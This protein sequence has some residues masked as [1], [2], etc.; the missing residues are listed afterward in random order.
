MKKT[1]VLIFL[2]A[3][4]LNC[5]A[6]TKKYHIIN[7][8]HIASAGKW[9]YIAINPVNHDIYVSHGTQVNILSKQGDSVGVILN[10]TGV[11]GI[12]FVPEFNKGFISNGKLNTVTVFDLANKQVIAQV[13][14]G[15]NPDAIMFDTFSKMVFVCNGHSN[16]LTII[17]PADNKVVNTIALGGKPETAVSDGAGNIYI[18]IEDK[19]EI[20]QL[21]AK[22]YLVQARWPLGKGEEPSGLAIDNKTHRLFSG[23]GNKLLAVV[24]AE[25][26]KIVENIPIGDE[27]DGVVFD[28]SLKQVFVS[29]GEGLLTVIKEESPDKYNV[30]DNVKT[31]PGARTITLDIADHLLYLPTADFMPKKEGQ[32]R[33]DMVPGTFR[34]LVVGK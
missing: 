20:V 25:N 2:I 16:D 23:C 3:L 9:D 1:F 24:N 26:G 4:V 22:T 6:Q 17:N 28:P 7:T 5:S 19:S 31:K 34:V 10:T 30:L 8:F 14:T 29:C 32:K 33:P 15:N 21:N 27:C 11:H 13:N 18:N 12:A